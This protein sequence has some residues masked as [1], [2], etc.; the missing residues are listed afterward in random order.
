MRDRFV[1]AVEAAEAVRLQRILQD[2]DEGE[3]LSFLEEHCREE[4]RRFLHGG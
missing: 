1:I 2:R 3:A 4:L